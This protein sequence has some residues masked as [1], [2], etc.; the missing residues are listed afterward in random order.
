VFGEYPLWAIE[1]DEDASTKRGGLSIP[2][3]EGLRKNA[4]FIAFFHSFQDCE[5]NT[6][7]VELDYES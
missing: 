2:N 7:L 4:D 6:H 5:L 3:G 1:Y